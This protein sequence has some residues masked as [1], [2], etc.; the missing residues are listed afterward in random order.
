MHHD[1]V[2]DPNNHNKPDIVTYYNQTKSGVDNFDHLLRL[3]SCKR[4]SNRWPMTLF[5]NI[6]DCGALS[7]FI[8]WTQ[9]FPEWQQNKHYKRRIFL[10]ELG[11][12]LVNQH[13]LRRVN[14]PQAM[15]PAVKAALH[16]LGVQVP[17]HRVPLDSLQEQQADAKG[18]FSALAG[19]TGKRRTLAVTAI[20]IAAENTRTSCALYA[21]ETFE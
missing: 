6:L 21:T 12:E 19:E 10:K 20:S 13:I 14:T 15:Q 2:I 3:Y 4:K 11:R 18:A 5:Y 17:A 16:S 1:E 8:L 9:K 7:A